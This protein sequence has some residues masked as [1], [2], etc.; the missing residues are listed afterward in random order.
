M[1]FL[2][3]ICKPQQ[4]LSL[5]LGDRLIHRVR[6]NSSRTELYEMRLAANISAELRSLYSSHC[7]RCS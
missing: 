4:A 3:R 2:E 5:P 1:R 7:Q 6:Y